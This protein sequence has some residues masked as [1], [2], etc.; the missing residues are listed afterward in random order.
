LASNCKKRIFDAD[1]GPG[2]A[3][4]TEVAS[5]GSGIVVSDFYKQPFV[6]LYQLNMPIASHGPRRSRLSFW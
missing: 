1:D 2:N 3:P 4:L 6:M 5:K